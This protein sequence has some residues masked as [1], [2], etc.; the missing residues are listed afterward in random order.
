MKRLQLRIPEDLKVKFDIYCAKNQVTATKVII[1]HIKELVEKGENKM[2][3]VQTL[4]Y[5]DTTTG[6]YHKLY[7]LTT[8]TN[9]DIDP[10]MEFAGL[11]V[12]SIEEQLGFEI[13][14]EN[15]TT[16]KE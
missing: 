12:E 3:N 8:D 9:M 15:L 11:T 5:H 14:V 6:I 16:E 1:D 7:E 13:D 10:L 4:Y 2:K